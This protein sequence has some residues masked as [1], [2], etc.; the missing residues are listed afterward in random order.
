MNGGECLGLVCRLKH[1]QLFIL[2][3]SWKGGENHLIWN[4]LPGSPPDFNTVID[5]A[6][7]NALIA[8]AGFDSWTYRVGF[9]VSLPV[10][11]P[12]A[13]TLDSEKSSTQDR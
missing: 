2:T 1:L 11:S 3:F 8:G 4:M 7:G 10:F 13:V 9:D 12:F 5:L 6:L